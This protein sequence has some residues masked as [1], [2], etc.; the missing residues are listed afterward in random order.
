MCCEVAWNKWAEGQTHPVFQ[1]ALTVSVPL[2]LRSYQ[3]A[4]CLIAILC[5]MVTFRGGPVPDLQISRL[6]PSTPVSLASVKA[7]VSWAA[8]VVQQCAPPWVPRWVQ[9]HTVGLQNEHLLL[10]QYF[11][12]SSNTKVPAGCC[13]C[14]KALSATRASSEARLRPRVHYRQG[15]LWEC[16]TTVLFTYIY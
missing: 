12:A 16:G 5:S 10:S 4:L 14:A 6:S 13:M 8:C 11:R 9:R 7:A 1:L 2:Q 15:H 3:E